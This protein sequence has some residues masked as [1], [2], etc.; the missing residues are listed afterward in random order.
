[1]W[2]KD[3]CF[4]EE[5]DKVLCVLYVIN[6]GG[7]ETK[8]RRKKFTCFGSFNSLTPLHSVF[9]FISVCRVIKNTGMLGAC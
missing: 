4:F 6:S 1:M 8:K 3:I 2:K 9:Y 5:K 7:I